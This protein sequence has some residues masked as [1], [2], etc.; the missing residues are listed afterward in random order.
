MKLLKSSPVIL[1]IFMLLATCGERKEAGRRLEEAK[2]M[3]E[4]KAFAAAKSLIDTINL[5]YPHEIK[6]RKEALTLMRLV[7]RGECERNIAYCDSV[8]PICLEE[9][10]FLK[11]GFAFEKDTAYDNI[12]K[13]VRKT[14]TIERNV[15][16]S[17]I[18][19]GVNEEGEMYIA[20]VYFGSNPI[21]HTGLKFSVGDGTLAETPSIPHD[22]GTNYRFNDM[23][24]TTEVVTY[25]GENCKT[26]AGFVSVTDEKER[27]KAE[28]TGGKPFS[29]YLSDND[30]KDIKA[31]YKLA[32][33]LNEINAMQK[34][35][36]RSEKK[37]KFIDEKLNKQK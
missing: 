15:E 10:E 5:C 27:I 30:K 21:H 33:V 29:L 9:A 13:Y 14:M 36:V 18:R 4:N 26:I 1:L 11:K 31:T 23:G 17:Y 12:G 32:M 3:Y 37:I 8:L 34:E 6:V 35:K 24:N 20:S 28:Y 7:E 2:T 19:C 22:G 16:R 25:K